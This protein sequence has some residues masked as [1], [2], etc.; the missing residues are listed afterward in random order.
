MAINDIIMYVMM[1]FLLIGALDRIFEQFGGAERVLGKVGLGAVGRSIAGA[2]SEFEAGFTAMGSLALAMVGIIAL[3]PVIAKVLGPVIM[4]VYH[5]LGANPAMFAGSILAND[6]GGFFLAREMAGGDTAAMLY[7][8]LLLGA[9]MGPTIVFIIPVA[10]G[11]IEKEDSRCM[12]LGILAGIVTI[13]LGT[14]AGGATA[15]YSGVEVNGEIVPFT[16]NML[17]VNMIPVIILAALI[18]LGLKLMPQKMINGFQIFAKLLV[19]LITIGLAAAVVQRI[20]GWTLIPGMDPIFMVEGDVPG[21]VM[22]AMETI[23]SIAIVLLGA[24]PMVLLLTRWFDK[25]LMRAGSA[26]KMNEIATG[27]MIA[28]LANVIPMFGMMKN[29]DNRGKVINCAFAVSAAFTFGD[30]LGF[31][32]GVMAPMILPM[33]VGKLVGGVT[34]VAVAILLMPKDIAESQAAPVPADGKEAL[35]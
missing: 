21:G 17:L 11:I 34:A 15:M 7:S 16:W 30:H 31:T 32:A 2:G 14:I 1:T 35:S 4:P 6:M 27:G 23:G 26:L 33:I 10:L 25:P 5:F 13:P 24:Y 9:M 28:T 22:R 20:L 29:M 12:A 18:C 19:T 3:A 8:G